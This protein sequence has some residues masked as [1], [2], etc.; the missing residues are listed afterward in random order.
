[1]PRPST[2]LL[3]AL[4]CCLAS[5]GEAV[6]ADGDDGRVTWLPNERMYRPYL[7]DPLQTAFAIQWVSVSDVDIV[8]TG[9]PR[10][11]L[12][13]GGVFGF[14]RLHPR[15]QPDKGWQVGIEAGFN[16]QFDIENGYDSIGWDGILGLLVSTAWD[17]G[18]SFQ[19]GGRH[20]SAH[21]GDEIIERT[22]RSRIEYTREEILAAL[23]WKFWNRWRV[24]GEGAWAYTINNSELQERPRA[25]GGLEYERIEAFGRHRRGGW[26]AA[27]NASSWQE[28]DWQVDTSVLAGIVFRSGERRWRLA[29][30]Y[31]RGTVPLGEF[32]RD[33]ETY[34]SLALWLDL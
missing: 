18:L 34:L 12:K 16:A 15:G 28:K 32:F 11:L 8:G 31:H 2:F 27:V 29:S 21:I 9:E 1:M 10:M 4:T 23:S 6:T 25:Q 13:L 3:I 26:F 24:Y 14:L 20:R 30:G 7:A 33:D 19:A 5:A 22:G 17:N